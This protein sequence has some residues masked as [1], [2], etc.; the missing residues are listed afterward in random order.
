MSLSDRIFLPLILGPSSLALMLLVDV[1]PGLA[2]I[3]TAEEETLQQLVLKRPKAREHLLGRGHI[4]IKFNQALLFRCGSYRD[5][6]L[7]PKLA[8]PL[9]QYSGI[10]IGAGVYSA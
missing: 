8:G 10:G 7:P 9:Y 1:Q 4:W 5:T 2:A 6:L 3:P